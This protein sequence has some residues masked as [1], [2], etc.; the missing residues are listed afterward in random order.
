M[1]VSLTCFGFV[2]LNKANRVQPAPAVHRQ[3]GFIPAE[4]RRQKKEAKVSKKVL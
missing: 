2:F 3:Q 4:E 1:S